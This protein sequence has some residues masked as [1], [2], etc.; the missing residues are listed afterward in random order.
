MKN[1]KCPLCE[2]NAGY[3]ETELYIY[4]EVCGEFG[5]SRELMDDLPQEKKLLGHRPKVSAFTRYREIH[6]MP[7]MT[8]L[9]GKPKDSHDTYISIFDVIDLFPK[10]LFDR[11]DRVISNIANMSRY[12]G[13][14]FD[15]K[16]QPYSIF[17]TETNE[18]AE[19]R[20]ILEQL[21]KQEFIDA[22]RVNGIEPDR[23]M[24]TFTLSSKGWERY[25]KIQRGEN[26]KANQ[27]FIA[28]MFDDEV[29]G[30]AESIN[31]A[32]TRAGYDPMRIDGKEHNEKICEE[33]IAEIRRSRFL[34]ADF[35]GHRGGVYF[36]AGFAM[37]LGIPV[38]WTCRKEHF[39][40]EIHF[41]TRQYNHI[42]WETEEELH[43]RLYNR[44]RAT[45]V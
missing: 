33:I 44:I 45:I 38:I 11:I 37:R 10:T 32:I 27:A 5:I 22:R 24:R 43:E 6:K 14:Y 8:L 35:T 30:A 19:K 2:T 40:G 31:A 18:D 23:E 26:H 1:I 21:A 12:V 34:I 39:G 13:E 17:M 16:K 9:F 7:P 3:L 15:V 4:C 36:E 28:M 41:D 20:F 25:Q 29:A 42:V